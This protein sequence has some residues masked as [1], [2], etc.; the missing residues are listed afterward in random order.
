MNKSILMRF[1]LLTFL[2]TTCLAEQHHFLRDLGQFDVSNYTNPKRIGLSAGG[3]ALL[4]GGLVARNYAG[5]INPHMPEPVTRNVQT[6]DISETVAALGGLVTLCAGFAKGPESLAM[7]APEFAKTAVLK[8]IMVPNNAG[9]HELLSI[10]GGGVGLASTTD[11]AEWVGGF[12]LD[13]D[14]DNDVEKV[15]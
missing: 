8:Q 3:L 6:I 9:R 4:V 14:N 7:L 1:S 5:T 2:A 10:L 13:R 12:L 15:K 11:V